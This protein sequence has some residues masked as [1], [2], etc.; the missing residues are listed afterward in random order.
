M[1]ENADISL[2]PATAYPF[3]PSNA[4]DFAPI[5]KPELVRFEYPLS[6][7]DWNFE[8]NC[9]SNVVEYGWISEI[10]YR[11]NDG[12]AEFILIPRIPPVE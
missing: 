5:K 4:E 9:R 10:N 7:E 8:Y 6:F 1:P 12:L 3:D 2:D 11:I